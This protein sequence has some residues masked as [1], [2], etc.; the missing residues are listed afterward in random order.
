MVWS[1]VTLAV[2]AVGGGDDGPRNF[3]DKSDVQAMPAHQARYY[4]QT[5]LTQ[6]A[7]QSHEKVKT[8]L[9]QTIFTE[10][11]AHML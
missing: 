3:H 1:T 10:F 8:S 2:A 5:Q 11:T 6:M 4:Y 7:G 9:C